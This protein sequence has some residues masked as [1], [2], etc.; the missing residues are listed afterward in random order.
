MA[1]PT[2][3]KSLQTIPSS[4]RL[5][6]PELLR[7]DA[8]RD[9]GTFSDLSISD[10][11]HHSYQK[12]EGG[13]RWGKNKNS[14]SPQESPSPPANWR[15]LRLDFFNSAFVVRPTSMGRDVRPY[16]R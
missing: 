11:S 15:F 10:G 7:I 1:S 3:R 6:K 13:T 9:F 16:S 12:Y 5:R 2:L 4:T 8:D 14:M